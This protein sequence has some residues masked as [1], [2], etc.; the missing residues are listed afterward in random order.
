MLRRM[1]A[2]RVEFA[3]TRRSQLALRPHV[4]PALLPLLSALVICAA[5]VGSWRSIA[6]GRTVPSVRCKATKLIATA[7]R[8]KQVLICHAASAATGSTFDPACDQRADATLLK[9]FSQADTRGACPS[10]RD[11]VFTDS[12]I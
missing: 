4:A 6:E 9:V 12:T 5:V 2:C 10:V 8:T 7:K 3:A 11:F 1:L